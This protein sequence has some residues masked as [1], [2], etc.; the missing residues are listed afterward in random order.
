METFTQPRITGYRQLSES[1]VAVMNF[2]KDNAPEMLISRARNHVAQQRQRQQRIV[3]IAERASIHRDQVEMVYGAPPTAETTF[4]S[5]GYLALTY[6]EV[7]RL[8][9]QAKAEIARIDAAQPERWIAIANTHFQEGLMAL[10]R[11]VAQPS[12]F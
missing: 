11:A 7:A 5:A 6:P 4:N 8:R 10:T 9:E 3:E 2:I 1:D 12:S